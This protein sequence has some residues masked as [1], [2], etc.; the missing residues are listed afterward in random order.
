MDRPGSANAV[1]LEVATFSGDS[2]SG[3]LV[4]DD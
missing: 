2:G 3:A 4:M 1:E